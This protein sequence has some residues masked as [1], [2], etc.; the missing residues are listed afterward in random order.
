MTEKRE[1]TEG[2]YLVGVTFNVGRNPVIEELKS[3]GAKLID[4]IDARA[5]QRVDELTG[6]YRDANGNIMWPSLPYT[7]SRAVREVNRNAA[8]AKTFMEQAMEKAVKAVTR[9]AE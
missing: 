2:E 3:T 1:L 7:V 8:M 6:D 5:K 4:I 9:S